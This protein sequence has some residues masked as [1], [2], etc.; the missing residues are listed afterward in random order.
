MKINS[1]LLVL[2]SERNISSSD[3][4]TYIHTYINSCIIP[5]SEVGWPQSDTSLLN[6]RQQQ[7]HVIQETGPLRACKCYDAHRVCMY[8]CMYACMHVCMNGKI[9]SSNHIFIQIHICARLFSVAVA[10]NS[11]THAHMFMSLFGSHS[12]DTHTCT[13]VTFVLKALH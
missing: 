5:E 2:H 1:T 9:A 11:Y 12:P 13:Y 10:T 4:S 8:V 7:R 3:G 6:S